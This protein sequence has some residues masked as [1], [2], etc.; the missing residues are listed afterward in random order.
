MGTCYVCSVCTG[1]CTYSPTYV[2]LVRGIQWGHV[3]CIAFLQGFVRTLQRTLVNFII[4]T[5]LRNHYVS[6]NEPHNE[7]RWFSVH[8]LPKQVVCAQAVDV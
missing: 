5:F 2:A 6:R 4:Y 7:G 8:S 3:T 1:F